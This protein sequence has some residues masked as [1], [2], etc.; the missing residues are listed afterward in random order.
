MDDPKIH[1]HIRWTKKNILDWEPFNTKHEALSHA[2]GFARAGDVFTIEEV[3][4]PCPVC[5]AKVA[6]AN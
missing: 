6:S 2:I 5:G 1:Y 3:S 4:T